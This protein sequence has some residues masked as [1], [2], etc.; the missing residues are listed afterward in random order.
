MNV[1]VLRAG[2]LFG[3]DIDRTGHCCARFSNPPRQVLEHRQVSAEIF[4]PTCERMP[5]DSVDA[6]LIGIVQMFVTP[7]S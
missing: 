1:E 7:G 6:V 3:I 2:D 4:N 5:V